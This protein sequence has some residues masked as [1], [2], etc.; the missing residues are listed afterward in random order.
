M[1]LALT[2]NREG[3]ETVLGCIWGFRSQWLGDSVLAFKVRSV[4]K[5]MDYSHGLALFWQVTCPSDVPK[6][7]MSLMVPCSQA[8]FPTVLAHELKYL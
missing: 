6:L 2:E 8:A 5:A 4:G 1:K 3:W 7:Q